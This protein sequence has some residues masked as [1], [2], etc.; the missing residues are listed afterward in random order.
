[1]LFPLF[2]FVSVCFFYFHEHFHTTVPTCSHDSVVQMNS[3][4]M[5]ISARCG[6]SQYDEAQFSLAWYNNVKQSTVNNR[7]CVLNLINLTPC[8]GWMSL[9]HIFKKNKKNR[10]RVSVNISMEQ[11]GN[12]LRSFRTAEHFWQNQGWLCMQGHAWS[13][14]SSSSCTLYNCM[15]YCMGIAL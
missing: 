11:N 7:Q 15:W 4:H 1:M 14:W 12:P 10:V 5:T 3:V 2:C 13:I 6:Q 8:Y 9:S